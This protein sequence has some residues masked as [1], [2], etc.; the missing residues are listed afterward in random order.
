MKKGKKR[1][2]LWLLGIHM[3]ISAFTFGGGYVV[4]PMIRKYFVLQKKMFGE[5]EL[6]E[7]AAVSQSAPGAIAVNLGGHRIPGG[8]G[9]RGD[10]QCICICVPSVSDNG[11]DL[12]QLSGVYCQSCNGGCFKGNAGWSSGIDCGNRIRNV[13]K[14]LEGT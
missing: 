2:Y 10:Y 9:V 4:V 12:P 11:S 14:Y 7:M 3:F 8:W 1:L 13:Q 6:A 5:E